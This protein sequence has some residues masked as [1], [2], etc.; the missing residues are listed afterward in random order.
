VATSNKAIPPLS[1]QRIWRLLRARWRVAVAI[2]G[3]CFVLAVIY[4]HF[5]QQRYTVQ[6][7]VI[8]VQNDEVSSS[9]GIAAGQALVSQLSGS[10]VQTGQQGNLELYLAG[11]RSVETARVLAL[12]P[13]IMHRMFASEWSQKDQ[14][15]RPASSLKGLMAQNIKWVLGIYVPPWQPP[16]SIRVEEYLDQNVGVSRSIT[17][18]VVGVNISTSDKQF[19]VDLLTVLNDSI[20]GIL[21]RRTLQRATGYIAYLNGRIAQATVVEYRESLAETIVQQE[22]IRMA[23]ASGSP[24]AA[25]VFSRPTASRM[26]TSPNAELILTSSILLGAFLALFELIARDRFGYYR[27]IF[28]Q[29]AHSS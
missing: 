10:A 19:G 25:D 12:H 1:P 13:D 27:R 11:L 6:M 21:R 8:A 14:Q 3:V 17:S 18:P 5:A 20:D 7:Q 9:S 24:Y 22:K 4:L 16:D 29:S 15:W 26:P 28:I 2:V 23:A